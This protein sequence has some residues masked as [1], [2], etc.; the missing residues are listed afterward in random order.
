MAAAYALK[1][2]GIFESGLACRAMARP[3]ARLELVFGTQR[4]GAGPVSEEEWE[5]FLA[6]EITPRF[7]DGLTVISGYGQW[8]GAGGTLVKEA[9]RMLVI[10]YP[11][12]DDSSLQIEAIRAAYKARFG[13]DSV[14]RADS[15]S[16]VS[17]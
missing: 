4:K 15:M 11:A 12:Q 14:L 3:L 2:R 5:S 7:P 17:F 8:R 10:W 13:Q 6:G 9:S 16:C 1:P